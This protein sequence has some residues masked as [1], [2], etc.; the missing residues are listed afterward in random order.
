MKP[1]PEQSNAAAE[2]ADS[3]THA[4]ADHNRSAGKALRLAEPGAAS[5]KLS[6]AQKRFNNLLARMDKLHAQIAEM[7]TMADAHRTVQQATLHPLRERF[8][9]SL[10][11]MAL[12]LDERLQGKRLPP[13]Q[14][15]A[16]FDIFCGLCESLANSG[17]DEMR[18]L[19]DQRS[20]Q[21]VY[22]KRR[23]AA[24]AMQAQMEGFLGRR[25]DI[26]IAPDA[27]DPL[28]ALLQQASGH[29]AHQAHDQ[30]SDEHPANQQQAEESAPA[31]R[32]VDDRFAAEDRQQQGDAETVLRKVYRQL[33]SALHPDRER[34]LA[35]QKHKTALMSE[36][37]AAYARQDLMALLHIQLRIEQASPQSLSQ[38]PAEQM[39]TMTL[40]LKQQ[41][42]ALKYELQVRGDA[43]AREFGLSPYDKLTAG[44][45]RR[46][47][48]A[49][50]R[51]LT[52]ELAQMEEDL[53][54]VKFDEGL[55][56][57]LKKH[58]RLTIRPVIDNYF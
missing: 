7:Q 57:W 28:E 48:S 26:D 1:H 21:S 16:A 35:V 52:Q 11:A 42:E 19:H 23:A 15:R 33:A 4:S 14:S 2:P 10:R 8:R 24:A 49:E 12:W 56:H 38:I 37:N 41:A 3:A 50:E 25:L 53:K 31:A 40:L 54:I 13:A 27:P 29:F 17:D 36:A 20:P 39:A 32:T 6:P 45:L 55:K 22:E 18:A 9:L 51:A 30:P 43:L 58:K 46:Q 5:A 47:L 44:N 34:D